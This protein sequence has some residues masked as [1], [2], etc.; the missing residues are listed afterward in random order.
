[1]VAKVRKLTE[2]KPKPPTDPDPIGYEQY[3]GAGGSRYNREGA[4]GIGWLSIKVLQNLWGRKLDEAVMAF[5]HGLR[6]SVVRISEGGLHADACC[7]RVTIWVK[8][9]KR[10]LFV[11][12]IFQEVEVLLP[13][14]VSHG[15]A[16]R[17]ALEWGIDS[18]EVKWHLDATGYFDGLCGY[19]KDTKAGPVRWKFRARKRSKKLWMSL[20]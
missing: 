8:K 20:K 10:T 16:L 7:W 13:E 6:P 15:D 2:W 3:L 1:M 12:E 19:G 17:E 5:V 9:V 4:R 14:G 18:P 11:R